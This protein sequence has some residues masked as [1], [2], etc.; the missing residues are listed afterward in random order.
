MSPSASGDTFGC[1]VHFSLYGNPSNVGSWSA[2]QAVA[3]LWCE[4]Q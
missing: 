3:Y 2:D 4:L 1:P